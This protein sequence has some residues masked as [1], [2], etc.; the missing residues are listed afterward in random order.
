VDLSLR[1]EV[2][3]MDELLPEAELQV[4]SKTLRASIPKK[5]T[6][7][8]DDSFQYSLILSKLQSSTD[9]L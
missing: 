9:V 2:V 7:L 5:E 6:Y 4:L 1:I 3:E 8:D